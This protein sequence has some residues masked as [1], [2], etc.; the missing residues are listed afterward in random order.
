[1]KNKITKPST[2]I[3]TLQISAYRGTKLSIFSL[4]KR[5]TA[6]KI[7]TLKVTFFNIRALKY[8]N[9]INIKIS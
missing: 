2:K 9:L 7:K 8:K 1:M 3:S 5:E 4:A 6:L